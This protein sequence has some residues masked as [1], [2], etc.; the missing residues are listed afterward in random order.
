MRNSAGARLG[1]YCV[2]M[3]LWDTF[4]INLGLILTLDVT[5]ICYA[6]EIWY[7]AINQL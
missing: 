1:Y 5:W 6:S 2:F 4:S 7:V 3:L